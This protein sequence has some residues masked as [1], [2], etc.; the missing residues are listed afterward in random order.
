MEKPTSRSPLRKRP[1]VGR[2]GLS[3]VSKRKDGVMEMVVKSSSSAP[4]ASSSMTLL[5]SQRT[6]S[7]MREKVVSGCDQNILAPLLS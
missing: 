3:R 7:H 1:R 2:K 4:E 6:V 5:F